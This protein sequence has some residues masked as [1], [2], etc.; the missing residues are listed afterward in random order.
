MRTEIQQG[1][2]FSSRTSASRGEA[3]PLATGS[4]ASRRPLSE[5]SK[6]PGNAMTPQNRIGYSL[7][8]PSSRNLPEVPPRLVASSDADLFSHAAV[9]ATRQSQTTARSKVPRHT[10][11]LVRPVGFEGAGPNAALYASRRLPAPL[12][13]GPTGP[14]LTTSQVQVCAW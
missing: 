2:A 10:T 3:Q 1:A 9:P 8:D 14:V 13:P 12:R 6:P 11:K 5:T 4:S 7:R